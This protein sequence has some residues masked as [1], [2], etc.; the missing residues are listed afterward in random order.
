M[1]GIKIQNKEWILFSAVLYILGIL[2]FTLFNDLN[3]GLKF[4]LVG[5]LPG[6]LALVYQAVSFKKQSYYIWHLA[7]K[8]RSAK[9]GVRS[10]IYAH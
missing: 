6:L 4:L 9:H 1:S 5:S 3:T 8:I 2:S 10:L 7:D